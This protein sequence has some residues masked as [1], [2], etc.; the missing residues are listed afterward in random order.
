MIP[1]TVSIHLSNLFPFPDFTGLEEI[2]L[3]Q[4]TQ[5]GFLVG[6]ADD[7]FG[8]VGPAIVYFGVRQLFEF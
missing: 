1:Y 7:I 3:P 4:S 8:H 2:D 5:F 6:S